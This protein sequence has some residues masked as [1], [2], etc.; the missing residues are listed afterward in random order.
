MDRATY[1]A[2]LR[3]DA[4]LLRAAAQRDPAAPAPSCPGWT[5][6]HLL[7]HIGRT[8]NW[9]GEIVAARSQGPIGIRPDDHAFDRT[10]AGVFDWFDRSLAA[11]VATLAATDPDEPVWSWSD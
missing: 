2:S 11:F 9:I 1:L 5:T 8:Y 10:D 4:A 7:V 3:A 6:G